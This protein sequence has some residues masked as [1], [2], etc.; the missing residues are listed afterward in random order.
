METEKI[1]DAQRKY[2]FR[3]LSDKGLSKDD[4]E[5]DMGGKGISEL[6]KIEASSIIDGLLKGSQISPA[7]PTQSPP[8]MPSSLETMTCAF[9]GLPHIG[10]ISSL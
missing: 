4:L 5:R 8:Y 6:S 2:L 9:M 1:T 3:V 7:S 10:Q